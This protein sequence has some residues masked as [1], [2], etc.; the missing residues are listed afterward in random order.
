MGSFDPTYKPLGREAQ[1]AFELRENRKA[2]RVVLLYAAQWDSEESARR[3]FAA[4]RQ[5]LEGKWKRIT[6][7]SESADVVTGTGD[8]GAFELRRAGA[9]VT[10]VEGR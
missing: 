5:V 8:D 1:S 7:A 6:V 9:V 10:S 2:R 3:Y 4:Y